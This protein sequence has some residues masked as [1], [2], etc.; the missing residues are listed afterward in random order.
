MA[1]LDWS[2]R[3]AL[4]LSKALDLAK[5]YATASGEMEQSIQSA[6]ATQWCVAQPASGRAMVRRESQ[7]FFMFAAWSG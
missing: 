2:L 7:L 6:H 5:Q 3:M 4:A 1:A